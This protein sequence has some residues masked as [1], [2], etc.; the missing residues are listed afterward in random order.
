MESLTG[1]LARNLA[2]REEATVA[3]KRSEA[4]LLSERARSEESRERLMDLEQEFKDLYMRMGRQGE[5]LLEADMEKDKLAQQVAAMSQ[6]REAERIAE[7][8]D[9]LRELDS[10]KEKEREKEA[11][12]VV[13]EIERNGVLDSERQQ[14]RLRVDLL[15]QKLSLPVAAPIPLLSHG[16]E[17]ENE[18][19]KEVEEL[20]AARD[21][22]TTQNN[23]NERNIRDLYLKITEVEKD[24]ADSEERL[25]RDGASARYVTYHTLLPSL[26]PSPLP[27]LPPSLLPS[28]PPTFTS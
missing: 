22:L 21:A 16:Q 4:L 9:R 6:E 26:P 14:M 20:K 23:L 13:Q 18:L 28:F 7:R 11:A 25:V 2:S 3:A 12:R 8:E 24:K 27:F 19:E 1:E 10:D 15:E 5:L 17:R